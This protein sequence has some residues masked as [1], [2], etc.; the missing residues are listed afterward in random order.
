MLSRGWRRCGEILYKPD[1]KETCC[2]QYAIRLNPADFKASK[3]QKGVFKKLRKYLLDDKNAEEGKR[4]SDGNKDKT[5]ESVTK[6]DT[7]S[8]KR[9]R[10]DIE[11]SDSNEGTSSKKHTEVRKSSTKKK[12]KA[13]V[14]G[15]SNAADWPC[16]DGSYLLNLYNQVLF[17]GCVLKKQMEFELC[18]AKYEEE[19]FLLYKKY[20]MNV[21]SDSEDSISSNSYN[22]FLVKSC[23][24]LQPIPGIEDA[25]GKF[26]F[27]SELGTLR[28][29]GTHHVKYRIDGQLV[30]VAVVD[31]IPGYVSSVYFFY[32]TDFSFLSIGRYSALREIALTYALQVSGLDITHYCMGY[33][34]HKNDKMNYKGN[35]FPSQLL[36]PETYRWGALTRWRPLLDNK[37]YCTLKEEDVDDDDACHEEKDKEPR[38]GSEITIGCLIQTGSQLVPFQLVRN[39]LEGDRQNIEAFQTYVG[40]VMFDR[41]IILT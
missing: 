10:A 23:L 31:F 39:H 20:Q 14:V 3:S 8:T 25:K 34:I 26:P 24:V 18:E 33:Y 7:K 11:R 36:C 41:S 19:S 30:G 15:D 13:S 35:Y 2:R 5:K 32:D 16:G 6:Q 9:G 38:V 29:Y 27:E 28:N 17:K 37:D 4:C 40:S 1:M 12:G 21:H 22:N